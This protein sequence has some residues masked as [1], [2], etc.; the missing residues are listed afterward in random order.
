MV[1]SK[2]LESPSSHNKPL[3][4]STSLPEDSGYSTGTGSMGNLL[5][6]C[7]SDS[8]SPST[9]G[10]VLWVCILV[11]HNTLTAFCGCMHDCVFDAVTP[12]KFP[13]QELNSG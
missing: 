4:N 11:I 6:V 7:G 5:S 9:K 12:L 1:S 10:V 2:Q 8:Q 13:V 3:G